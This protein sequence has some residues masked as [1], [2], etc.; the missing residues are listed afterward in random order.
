MKKT[1]LILSMLV[2]MFATFNTY[3]QTYSSYGST[4]TNDNYNYVNNSNDTM[5][6]TFNSVIGGAYEDATLTIDGNAY[7]YPGGSYNVY[8][9]GS[10]LV[11]N[12]TNPAYYD[13]NV[14]S[15]V[16]T[17]P[18]ATINSYGGSVVYKFVQQGT[19]YPNCD[20]NKLR[21]KLQYNYCTTGVPAQQASFSFTD[22]LFCQS[23]DPV[24][25][26]GS[27]TGGIFSG[28]GITNGVLDPSGLPFGIYYA[29]YTF[30]EANGCYTQD[31]T[32]FTVFENPADQSMTACENMAPILNTGNI[33][34]VYATDANLS[35]MIGIGT[36]VTLN[37][38]T[39]NPTEVFSAVVSS[40]YY[41]EMNSLDTSNYQMV[42]HDDLSGDDRGGIAVTANYVYI[43]GDDAT[44]RYDLDLQNGTDFQKRDG[45][46]TDL[47]Q[48][49][50]Y[51]LYN[52]TAPFTPN[53]DNLDGFTM[54]A[55]RELNE[56]LSY[57]SEIIMLSQPVTI[58]TQ[59]QAVILAGYNELIVGSAYGN[60]DFYHISILNGVVTP[61]GQHEL[62]VY[63]SENW[64]DWGMTGFDGTDRHAYFRD[65][66]DSI[67]DFNFTTGTYT[68][69]LPITDFS[70]LSSFIAHP[71]NQRFYGHY[72]SSTTTFGG[73]QENLF[74][75]QISDSASRLTATPA[76]Y[77]C[78]N[79]I[80]FTF[81]TLDLGADTTVCSEDGLYILPGGNGYSSYTW[82]GV[83][84]NF[85]SYP[86]QASG[87]IVLSVVDNTN[88]TLTDSINVTITECTAGI[89][90][91]AGTSMQ[92]YPVPNN[93][94]F[95]ITF[96]ALTSV[97]QMIIV[98]AQGKQIAEK[99]ISQGETTVAMNL[100]VEPGIYFV[101]LIS[102]NGT[103]QRAISI[104]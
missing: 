44:A 94:T 24:N 91:L 68:S 25:L 103:S 101:R 30:T 59:D 55:L 95:Q 75:F 29:T 27:P 61:M 8:G 56:D 63:G 97:S 60:Q 80:T 84:N 89:N 9:P 90:E 22:S 76:N 69:I 67:V 10:V 52:T 100:S 45:I 31:S 47:A 19:V 17:I 51:T 16:I 85:N 41:Y 4:P 58:G 64:A 49:K 71:V 20:E 43:V 42:D 62:N 73:G 36:N 104:Q 15:A 37:P 102:E 77:A 23:N 2:G 32:S 93:G 21:A 40:P 46:F 7:F 1:Y 3:S 5:Y 38:I 74:Y 39:V 78:P 33:S 99:T 50:L 6:Y 98:D 57:G 26:T 18:F 96:D 28:S 86:V 11:G 92:I 81:N 79:M 14:F 13:C 54:N 88:C 72:E 83:N 66:N 65:E 35:N 34:T 82:N 53:S 87:E 70:D 48:L 12:F